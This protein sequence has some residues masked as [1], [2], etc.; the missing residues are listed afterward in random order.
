M[1][2]DSRTIKV[3][4]KNRDAGPTAM[5][6]NGQGEEETQNKPAKARP[7]EDQEPAEFMQLGGVGDQPLFGTD[8]ASIY[9]PGDKAS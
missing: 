4:K 6:A 5:N 3:W 8:G 7:A 1:Q 2:S 9:A